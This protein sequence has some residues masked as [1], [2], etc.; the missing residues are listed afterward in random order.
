MVIS[1]LNSFHSS[2]LLRDLGFLVITCIESFVFHQELLEEQSVLDRK[3]ET[4]APK[5]PAPAQNEGTSS[6]EII[7]KFG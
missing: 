2:F 6:G 7:W 3:P 1:L 4:L 5:E